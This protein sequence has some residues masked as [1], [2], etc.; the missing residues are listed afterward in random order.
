M[1]FLFEKLDVYQKSLSFA[2][3]VRAL[4]SSF[5]PG[6]YDVADQLRRAALSVPANIAEGN[7]RWHSADKKHFFVVARGSAYECVPLLDICRRS[8][9]GE[10]QT[11][12]ELRTKLEEVCR[13]LGGL[14]KRVEPQ[15]S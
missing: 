15:K 1:A 5:P 8:S 7:G 11:I 6:N 10:L 12:N 14:V 4:C 13:M 2:E 3:E 9:L